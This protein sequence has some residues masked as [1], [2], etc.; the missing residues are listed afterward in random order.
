M[1]VAGL[2]PAARE[3]TVLVFDMS[4]IIHMVKPTRANVFGEYTKKHLLPFLES[5]MNSNTTRIDAVWDRY[6]ETSLKAHT[7]TKRGESQ[8]HRNRVLTNIPIPKG[9]AW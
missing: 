5:Q 6:Q 7:R 8:G 9:S 2:N 1:P 3:S 4:S